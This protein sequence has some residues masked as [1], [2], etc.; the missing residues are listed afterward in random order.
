VAGLR[1]P[2]VGLML[3][4]ASVGLDADAAWCR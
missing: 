2:V 4:V 3:V 1:C